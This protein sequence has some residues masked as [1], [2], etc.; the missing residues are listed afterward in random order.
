MG[1]AEIEAFLSYLAV[2][3]N[4]SAS[5]QNQAF[6]ALLFLYRE[7]LKLEVPWLDGFTPAK[8]A[9]RVPVVLTKEEVKIIINQLQGTNW[10]IANLH[11][12]RGFAPS[13]GFAFAGQGFGFRVSAN[14]RARRQGRERPF[15]ALAECFA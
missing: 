3:R 4:V 10:L 15:Y 6:C 1:A 11:D 2:E 14:R 7:V 12:E 9:S 13:G 5:T 8:K